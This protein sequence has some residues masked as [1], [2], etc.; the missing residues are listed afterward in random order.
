MY[1]QGQGVQKSLEEAYLRVSWASFLSKTN[2]SLAEEARD[3]IQSIG[4]ELTHELGTKK[5]EELQIIR[6]DYKE[7]ID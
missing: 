5:V 4:M 1:H 2:G 3:R 6:K 7:F